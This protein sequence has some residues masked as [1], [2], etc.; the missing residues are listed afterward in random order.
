MHHNGPQP[1]VIS[2]AYTCIYKRT[3]NTFFLVVIVMVM[4]Y[5]GGTRDMSGTSEVELL[6][7][8]IVI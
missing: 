3:K 4:V 5:G 1:Q 8:D 6:I 2:G 7:F